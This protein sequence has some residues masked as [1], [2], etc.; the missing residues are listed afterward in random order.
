MFLQSY[1]CS[2]RSIAVGLKKKKGQFGKSKEI[3]R[4]TDI[5]GFKSNC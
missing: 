2:T 3:D 5:I 1:M 4:W